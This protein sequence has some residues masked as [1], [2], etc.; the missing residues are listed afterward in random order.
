MSYR[1]TILHRP[2]EKYPFLLATEADGIPLT[3]EE[4]E[5]LQAEIAVWLRED[6]DYQA[7][8]DALPPHKR[9]GYAERM[10][11]HADYLRK[12]QRENNIT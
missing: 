8:Q 2:G 10:A 5:T 11:D 7:G 12:A 3:R 4:L 1:N 9:D 6:D